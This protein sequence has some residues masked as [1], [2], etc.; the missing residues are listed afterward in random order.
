MP[1]TILN[2]LSQTDMQ[3]N[4]GDQAISGINNFASEILSST[5]PREKF[6]SFV[7]SNEDAKTAMDIVNKYGNG[8]PKTAFMNYAAQSGKESLAKAILSRLGLG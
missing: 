2:K 7:S 8:D 6:N 1:S 4:S 5:N 3:V